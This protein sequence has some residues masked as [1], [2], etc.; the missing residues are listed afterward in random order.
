[1]Y[2]VEINNR[3]DIAGPHGPDEPYQRI[4]GNIV[5]DCVCY[6]SVATPE[7][8]ECKLCGGS[9]EPIVVGSYSGYLF[10]DTE[11]DLV[12]QMDTCSGDTYA[13]GVTLFEAGTRMLKP[14]LVE[15]ILEC[16]YDDED[17]QNVL[18]IEA[19]SINVEHRG[20]DL[21]HQVLKVLAENVPGMTMNDIL[22]WQA[23]SIESVPRVSKGSDEESLVRHWSRLCNNMTVSDWGTFFFQPVR[24][25][26]FDVLLKAEEGV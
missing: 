8:G 21:S 9:E 13:A 24:Q 16:W 17:V 12:M 7:E 1:M 15:K 3:V 20:S 26:W 5:G 2:R 14:H 22:C 4:S 23:G 6:E 18:Y 25:E 11:D 10:R 19:I